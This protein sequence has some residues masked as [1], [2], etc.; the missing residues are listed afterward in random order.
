[1]AARTAE[2][3]AEKEKSEI[4][5]RS[6]GDAIAMVDREMRIRYV[7]PAF[8]TLTGYTA[9]EIAG[10]PINSLFGVSR[11]DEAIAGAGGVAL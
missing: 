8:T 11:A 10:Q 1:M 9:Q 2:I 3:T 7:N 5:L 6:A 4:I